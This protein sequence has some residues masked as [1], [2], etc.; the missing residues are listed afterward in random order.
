ML[1]EDAREAVR[2]VTKRGTS[3]IKSRRKKQIAKLKA[4]AEFLSPALE[5]IRESGCPEH[6]DARAKIHGPLLRNILQANG[7]RG[8]AWCGQFANAFPMIGAL[9]EPG[10]YPAP[11]ATRTPIS[12]GELFRHAADTCKQ[13]KRGSDPNATGPRGEALAQVTKKWMT[14]PFSSN[15]QGD[16]WINGVAAR[17]NPAPRF[18][19]RKADKIRAGDDLEKSFASEATFI[20]TPVNMPTWRHIAQM[21]LFFDLRGE[22]RTLAMA[23]AGHAD[24]F[25][26]LP[27]RTEDVLTA[28]AT[29]RNYQDGFFFGFA[30][31]TQLFRAAAAVLHYG[32]FSRAVAALI[33]RV[34]RIP[35]IGY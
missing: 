23:K 28:A 27:L 33:C 16:M 13:A 10:V 4:A 20:S 35:C 15:A 22:I 18:G 11:E 3:A 31:G 25:R 21:C 8:Y 6:R 17:A 26:Q 1:P 34:L 7:V 30:P 14:G 9:G 19:V 24:A 2:F 5:R 12:R 29:L 32:S